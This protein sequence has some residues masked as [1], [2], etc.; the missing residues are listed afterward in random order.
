MSSS[1]RRRVV[2]SRAN[3]RSGANRS[4]PQTLADIEIVQNA[5]SVGADQ[6]FIPS[7]LQPGLIPRDRGRGTQVQAIAYMGNRQELHDE[8]ATPAW[9]DALGAREFL[10]GD[11]SVTFV[12][13]GQPYARQRWNDYS[14]IDVVVALRPP[15]MWDI[16]SK[17]AA[18]LQNAWAA[19]LPAILSSEVP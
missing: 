16:W 6:I 10:W 4:L 9:A 14:A 13:N 18:K 1:S 5:S 8:L 3:P 11:R 12:G 17:P 7:W 2:P 15:A 19:G